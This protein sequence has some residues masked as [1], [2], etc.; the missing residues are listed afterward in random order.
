VDAYDLPTLFSHREVLESLDPDEPPRMVA[1]RSAP[2]LGS[3]ALLPGS[4][5]PPTAAHLLLAERARREGF[6]CVLF[7]LARNT[8]DKE[9]NGLIPEDRLLS[10]R[11]VAQRAGMG[12]AVCSA[13]LYADMADAAAMLFP[14]TEIAFLVGSDKVAAIFDAAYYHDR[15][16]AL[17]ALFSRA[18]LIV[19]P[20]TDDGEGA[21]NALERSE[22]R[23]WAH[24]VSILPLHPAVS[25]LSSTRVRGMLQAGADPTGLVPSAVGTF[26]AEVGA[27]QA[28]SSDGGGDEG[29]D[30]YRIRA[31]LLEIL[32]TARE[33]A[34]R[35]ADLRALVRIAS[36][37][38][39]EGREL[40]R[41]IANGGARAEDLQAL[42][43]AG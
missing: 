35:A 14:G 37:P 19:A 18:R 22:N 26:L 39:E 2:T 6:G 24:R 13:G 1:L 25:D 29:V 21:R 17:D 15:E 43:S 12:V 20:R 31:K 8:V 30:R 28:T 9:P 32:W 38:G 23:A 40:R 34:E 5:N 16:A 10:L 7:V 41:L 4:F 33:W 36:D 3:M 42:Q 11:F 27:F